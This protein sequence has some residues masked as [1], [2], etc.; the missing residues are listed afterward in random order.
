MAVAAH[1]WLDDGQGQLLFMRRSNTGYA[2]GQWSVPAGHVES[3]ERIVEACIREI[4]EEIGVSLS[5]ADLTLRLVQQKI[6]LDQ[7]QRIDFFFGATLPSDQIPEIHEPDHCDGL[8]WAS[9]AAPPHPTVPYVAA[10][11]NY[12]EV[13]GG[14]LAYWGFE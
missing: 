1:L 11:L 9:P 5:F 12:F 8:I 3:G 7:E 14:L 13:G 6:D 2:D 10:A 4:R